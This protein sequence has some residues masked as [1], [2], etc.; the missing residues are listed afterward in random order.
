MANRPWSPTPA[1]RRHPAARP[2]PRTGGNRGQ[3]IRARQAATIRGPRVWDARR[4]GSHPATRERVTRCRGG[5]A[6]R[7]FGKFRRRDPPRL[8]VGAAVKSEHVALR[9]ALR[10]LGCREAR[11]W[12]AGVAT[13]LGR[14]G[15]GPRRP[16]ARS[17]RPATARARVGG[18][19]PTSRTG[20]PTRRRRRRAGV[21]DGQWRG[22]RALGLAARPVPWGARGRSPGA[23]RRARSRIVQ[24][25]VMAGR[26]RRGPA[27]ATWRRLGVRGGPGEA[28]RG[29]PAGARRPAPAAAAPMAR[30]HGPHRAPHI[31][32]GTPGGARCSAPPL[33]RLLR[34][35]VRRSLRA[36]PPTL[37]PA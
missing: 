30:P 33:R 1:R 13:A 24:A 17:M 35:A 18:E 29:G 4:E 20:G 27:R 36:P 16:R 10:C 15:P 28:E 11:G 25:A 19:R 32:R 37:P 26:G 14:E 31:G 2:G 7:L 5:S 9:V 21:A 34:G 3:S 23:S 22:P 6:A 8:F 12:S